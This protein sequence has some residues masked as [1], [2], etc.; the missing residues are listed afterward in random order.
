MWCVL[1]HKRVFFYWIFILISAKN[2][3]KIEKFLFGKEVLCVIFLNEGSFEWNFILIST[4]KA[5]TWENLIW[6]WNALCH[7]SQ[8]GIFWMKFHTNFSQK[9]KTKSLRVLI[10]KRRVMCH[11]S[12]GGIFKWNFI[13]ISA[14]N[15]HKI[16]RIWF[17][18][19]R[20]YFS[21][22]YLLNEISY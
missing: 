14:K 5:Q 16:E 13:L 18:M 6:N 3:H 8:G 20:S 2:K 12:Q 21:R 15:K 1:F 10:W 7:I 17:G 22:R 19:L 4:K 9:I 11:I